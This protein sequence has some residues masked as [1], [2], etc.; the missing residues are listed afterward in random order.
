MSR[1]NKS[2]C[3]E[4]CKQNWEENGSRCYF[5]STEQKSWWEAEDF[6]KEEGGHLAS[7]T[8]NAT[9]DYI[10]SERSNRSIPFLWIGGTDQEKEGDWKWTDGCSSFNFTFWQQDQP[11]DLNS[12]DCLRYHRE[13][14]RWFDY[15]CG[16]EAKFLCSQHLC[17][18][19]DL[20]FHPQNLLFIFQRIQRLEVHS[21]ERS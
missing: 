11:D 15:W 20:Y 12:Q 21:Y 2:E 8:S 6:C 14:L 18:G 13:D 19:K 3:V 16:N 5:W 1:C 10:M 17:S 7:V 9:N 4:T